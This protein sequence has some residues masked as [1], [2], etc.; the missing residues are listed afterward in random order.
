MSESIS[1]PLV[2]LDEYENQF[3]DRHR[4]QDVLARWAGLRPD[5]AALIDAESGRTVRWLEFDRQTTLLAAELLR[6]GFAKGDFLATMLPM[7]VDHVLLE[8]GCF[9]IGVTVAPLDLR[10]TA[11]EVMRALTL[12][13]PRGFAGLGVRGPMDLRPLWQLMQGACPW[14]EHGLVL[15]S[16]PE[17]VTGTCCFAELMLSASAHEFAESATLRQ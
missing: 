5:A 8:Y 12:L 11:P 16:S 10:L 1:F 15:D 14:V 9:K 6:R 13:K 3:A 7:S 17:P 2:T 4:L